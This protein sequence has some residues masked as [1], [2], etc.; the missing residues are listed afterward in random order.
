MIFSLVLVLDNPPAK[1][2]SFIQKF[3]T[4]G[5]ANGEFLFPWKVA[6]DSSDR[7]IVT[8][9]GN[10]RVQVFDS[11][12]LHLITFGT[13]GTS[14]GEFTNP[15]GV[16]V[17][18][19]DRIIVSDTGNSRIQIFNSAGLHLLS[20]GVNG[21]AAGELFI[22]LGVAV[23][24]LDRI[25]VADTGNNRTQIF[26]SVGNHLLSFGSSGTGDG[27][28]NFPTDVTVD[29]SDRIIV[30][31]TDSAHIR[32]FD[33]LGAEIQS[34]GNWGNFTSPGVFNAPAGVSVDIFDN[35][36]VADSYH[37]ATQI[38]N[39]TGGYLHSFGLN[40]TSNREFNAPMG[41]AVDSSNRIIIADTFNNRIQIFSSYSPHCIIPESGDW[42]ITQSCTLE[43]S[44]TVNGNVM[45]QNGA[46]L[47]IP[48]GLVLEIDFSN[49][50]LRIF[51]GGGVLIQSGGAINSGISPPPFNLSYEKNLGKKSSLTLED[52]VKTHDEDGD[53]NID[54][55]DGDGVPNQVDNC[56]G[57]K[58]GNNHDADGDGLGNPCD[59]DL[60]GDGHL[61]WIDNCPTVHNPNQSP[62]AECQYTRNYPYWK[63]YNDLI[64]GSLL[65]AQINGECLIATASFGSPMAKEVQMLREIRDN[66]L[67]LTKSGA[68]FMGGFNTVYYSFAPTIAQWEN[69][70]PA[71]KEIVK[72][73]IT[74]L[75]SSLSLLN[76]VSMDSEIEVLTYGIS[77][78][79]LNIGMYFVMPIAVF[80][81][82]K[83]RI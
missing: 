38:F 76:H 7:I 74:P 79:L 81:Q 14:D 73:T 53:G 23:D 55:D 82:V 71:F 35:I 56:P 41:L 83:K 54:D 22:P 1:A 10:N 33:N 16:T 20:F 60:D 13:V 17:D 36:F 39:S 40:G 51:S 50:S 31:D 4:N 5:T 68:A 30:T 59:S 32:I 69:E 61:N 46:V 15:T 75:I 65:S 47:T 77:L 67:L 21:T 49:F 44:S 37:N 18:S 27:Q 25:I 43:N 24:S 8:D 57:F 2:T 52:L 9:A 12:G 62:D 34:F 78:I 66:Q 64:A 72:I 58:S 6:T 45:V 3:G 70:I 19:T 28:F 63:P 42:S 11:T 48:N 29:S 26:D 80:W